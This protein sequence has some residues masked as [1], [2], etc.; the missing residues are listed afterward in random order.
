MILISLLSALTRVDLLLE[1]F[2]FDLVLFFLLFLE[3]LD[4][5]LG[6][7]L[8]RSQLHVLVVQGSLHIAV[9]FLLSLQKV[10]QVLLHL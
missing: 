9:H 2:E 5:S 3:C 1:L 8:D 6:A 4:V 7:V 10:L